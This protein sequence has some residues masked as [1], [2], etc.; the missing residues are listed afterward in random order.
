MAFSD[1]LDP[2]YLR[3]QV[4]LRSRTIRELVQRHLGDSDLEE[5]IAQ[6]RAYRLLVW[7]QFASKTQLI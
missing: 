5:G 7:L 2:P 3:C 4:V 6:H 1:K